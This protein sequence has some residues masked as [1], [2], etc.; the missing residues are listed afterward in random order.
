MIRVTNLRTSAPFPLLRR[1]D[2]SEYDWYKKE[3]KDMPDLEK[4]KRK[5]LDLTEIWVLAVPYE[6]QYDV[7]VEEDGKVLKETRVKTFKESF[8]F[9]KASAPKPVRG[10]VDN[11]SFIVIIASLVHDADFGLHFAP[12]KEANEIF[13]QLI[14]L[15]IRKYVTYLLTTDL[16]KREI[17]KWFR[18]SMREARWYKRGVST[19]FG[20][21]IYNEIKPEEHWNYGKVSER[22]IYA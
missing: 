15:V 12:Y 17:R 8:L 19:P 14:K 3:Y 13:F 21:A 6:I 18:D 9:D 7:E 4:V 10:I 5:N 2:F 22:R 11:D 20:K 16:D 1:V